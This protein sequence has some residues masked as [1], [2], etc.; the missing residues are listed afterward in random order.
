MSSPWALKKLMRGKNCTVMG[1]RLRSEAD[2][3]RKLSHPNI[4]G[5]RAFLRTSDGLECLA[6]E[7]CHTSLYDLIENRECDS[8]APNEIQKVA[9]NM[10]LALDYIH[11]E[12]HLLHGDIK[13]ANILIK[14]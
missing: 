11:N 3:L 14:G 5:F 4:V 10:G 12:I 13:S 7:K 6:M 8:F 1:K 9:L 2:I